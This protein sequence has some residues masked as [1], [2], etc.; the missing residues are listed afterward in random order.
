VPHPLNRAC[1]LTV[2]PWV[3]K[4]CRERVEAV[5]AVLQWLLQ[6]VGWINVFRR[7]RITCCRFKHL[8]STRVLFQQIAFA[9]V[10]FMAN[11]RDR[12]RSP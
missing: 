8:E 12:R 3:Q 10:T 9:L 1:C 11:R 2:F 7:L 4:T 5:F 6:Y